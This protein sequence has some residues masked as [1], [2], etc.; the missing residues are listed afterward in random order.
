[1]ML[2]MEKEDA[3]KTPASLLE[4][5]KQV[6]RLYRKNYRPM[7]IVEL[8]GLSWGAVNTA[9]KLYDEGGM[10]ALNPKKRGVKNGIG[11]T[12]DAEQEKRIQQLICE[13][14][15]EQL[16][17]G[18]ALWTRAAVKELILREFSVDLP[19]R[20]VG[21]YLHR[22]GFTPQK[23]IK[24][25]YEQQPK[26]VQKWLDEQYPEIEKRALEEG[27]EIHWGDETSIMNTDVRGRSYSP[28]GK[29]PETRAVWGKREKFSMISTVTNR[30]K[31]R[32]MMI[33]GAFNSDRLI[34]FME[35]LVKDAGR[36]VFL[37]LDNLRVHHSKP[38]KRWLMR[39]T[40]EIE[41]FF[42]PSYS[43]ELNPDERLNADL[44][45]KITTTA[46]SRTRRKL[47]AVV[48]QHMEL[49][50]RSPERVIKYFGDP[51]ISY[52]ANHNI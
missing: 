20:T 29:T 52:A 49:I 16:K 40:D 11:R 43:P 35:L 15:P 9:I 45:H 47:E 17:M 5:R 21:D 51:H 1:M 50:E 46:P 7:Q 39:H 2:Y 34:A 23:P 30:G 8:T 26:A 13:K 38:V 36:K 19:L 28:R 12:L 14:R 32:W 25:A 42:L 27:A 33:D 18:F 22:W 24:R 37:V 6:V 10:V 44:K 4:R 31:C 3:R 41:V 48:I